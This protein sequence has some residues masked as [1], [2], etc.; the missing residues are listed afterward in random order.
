MVIAYQKHN[1]SSNKTTATAMALYVE[2]SCRCERIWSME[3]IKLVN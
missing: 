1:S 2:A 3:V